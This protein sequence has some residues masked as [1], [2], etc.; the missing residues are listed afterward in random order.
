MHDLIG[1]IF[2][3]FAIIRLSLFILIFIPIT[4]KFIQKYYNLSFKNTFTIQIFQILCGSIFII[5]AIIDFL[6]YNQLWICLFPSG[7]AFIIGLLIVC[8]SIP[9]FKKNILYIGFS[10]IFTCLLLILG[11][12]VILRPKLPDDKLVIAIA[13]F[14]PISKQAIDA[15]YNIQHRIEKG[16]IKKQKLGAPLKIVHLSATVKYNTDEV[17]RNKNA[18]TI[19][20]SKV[21]IILWGD[22][23]VDDNELY[24]EP[25]FTFLNNYLNKKIR[26]IKLNSYES[27]Q[28]SHIKMKKLLANQIADII[29][30][31]AGISY[32]SLAEWDKAISI[33]NLVD[34]IESRLYKALSLFERSFIKVNPVTD[35]EKSLELSESVINSKSNL[36]FIARLNRANVNLVLL[37]YKHSDFVLPILEKVNI[38]YK[39]LEKVFNTSR[40]S[41]NLSCIQNNRALTLIEIANIKSQYSHNKTLHNSIEL[42]NSSLQIR[43]KERYPFEWA[44]SKNNLGI[45]LTELGIIDDN[46]NE[47]L[48]NAIKQYIE[49]LSI[50]TKKKYPLHW[51]TTMNN[52]GVTYNELGRRTEEDIA[53][54]YLYKS[55]NYYKLALEIR[56]KEQYPLDWATTIS[57]LGN[58]LRELGTIS[59]DSSKIEQSIN[60]F[61]QTFEVYNENL[62]PILWA[63]SQNSLG[64]TYRAISRFKDNKNELINL[65]IDSFNKSV[66]IRNKYNLTFLAYSTYM[67]LAELYYEDLNDND[68]SLSNYLKAIERNP[69]SSIAH[70]RVAYI[71]SNHYQEYQKAIE[72][73]KLCFE[74]DT[75]NADAHTNIAII[76]SSYFNEHLL[77]K[78][79]LEYALNL[80]PNNYRYNYNLAKL[81]HNYLAKPDSAKKLYEKCISLNSNYASAYNDLGWL[82]DRVYKD[83]KSAE[84]NYKRAI[85][86]DPNLDLAKNNLKALLDRLNGINK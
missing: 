48:N 1:K 47:I 78:K 74:F 6:F 36:V 60:C 16:L 8:F 37:K 31:L 42:L 57:N 35:L 40:D 70:Y 7:L 72:H 24:I 28:P 58:T 44:A 18:E 86:I 77:A 49:S 32:Y 15:S 43:T 5:Y 56:E 45:A 11:L 81:Y 54:G 29:T 12:N 20:D 25:R 71:Y 84:Y 38:E 67:N 68:N 21:H 59:N 9:K 69:S 52:L 82:L 62:L 80:D 65:A 13:R 34:N 83:Y 4:F 10:V 17:K 85:N 63:K 79:H 66:K 22:I 3:Y 75:N 76:Y 39:D 2:I 64:T 53:I 41:L 30:L 26:D 61:N 50:R 51:A 55:E 33:F 14:N 73:Y 46:N 19:C 27:I 23:R